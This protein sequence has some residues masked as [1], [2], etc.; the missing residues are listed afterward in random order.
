MLL[1]N[2]RIQ[3]MTDFSARFR[4]ADWP[5]PGI[6]AVAAGVYAVWQEGTLLYCGMS[7]RSMVSGPVEPPPRRHGLITRLHSHASG[8][9]SGDQ[10]CVYVA[11]RLVLPA[12]TSA[13]L[14]DFATGRHTLDANTR[15][16]I[17][18]SFE[19]QYR[20]TDSGASA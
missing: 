17:H 1:E 13:E 2:R 14:G 6:P 8:R 20:V 15:R 10:F 3:A 18:A 4:F 19:Y 16:L 7:G 5:N 9:L 11:N 12:L